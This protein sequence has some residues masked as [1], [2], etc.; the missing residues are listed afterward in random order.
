MCARAR[1]C[2]SARQPQCDTGIPGLGE[3]EGARAW[4]EQKQPRS[5]ATR[6]LLAVVSGRFAVGLGAGGGRET[7]WGLRSQAPE[8]GGSFTPSY[9]PR[10]MAYPSGTRAGAEG[11]RG[12]T[13][14]QGPSSLPAHGRHASTSPSP[15]SGPRVNQPPVTTAGRGRVPSLQRRTPRRPHLVD[16]ED[17]GPHVDAHARHGPDGGVH[18]CGGDA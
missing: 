13:P 6:R 8:D 12:H 10:D 14:A 4:P 15:P 1:D 5:V 9:L 16:Q 3:A 11:P 17:L 18:T 7:G 2:A